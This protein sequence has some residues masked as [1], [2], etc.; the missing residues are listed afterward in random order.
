VRLLQSRAFA[1]DLRVT[2]HDQSRLGAA[3]AVTP[4]EQFTEELSSLPAW[5]LAPHV[6]DVGVG[7]L[8]RCQAL[9]ENLPRCP[10]CLANSSDV[11][12]Q[13]PA[14]VYVPE[15]QRSAS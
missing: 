6:P 3:A 10:G 13:P 12:H 5:R 4:S 8:C 2:V 7:R 9:C 15:R 1:G 11:K 14:P